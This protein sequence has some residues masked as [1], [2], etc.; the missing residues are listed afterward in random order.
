VA[1]SVG[2]G[3]SQLPHQYSDFI[4]ASCEA[5]FRRTNTL[6]FA[7]FITHAGSLPTP[8]ADPPPSRPGNA[9]VMHRITTSRL[10]YAFTAQAICGI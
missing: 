1:E 4:S 6:R 9:L 5:V 3:L 2:A 7:G 8:Y 10:K